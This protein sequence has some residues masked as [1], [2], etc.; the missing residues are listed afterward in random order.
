MI[1][2]PTLCKCG[3]NEI[4]WNGNEYI[5]HHNVRG[6]NNYVYGKGYLRAKNNNGMFNKN[7]S[8][9]S[10][11][12]ISQ[13]RSG[14]CLGNKNPMAQL[15]VRLKVSGENSYLW[16]GGISFGQYSKKFN[17]YLKDKIRNRDNRICKECSK[18]ELENKEKLTVHHIDYNKQNCEEFNLI[19]LC[20]SCNSKVNFNRNYW[21]EHFMKKLEE[22]NLLNY[23]GD[24]I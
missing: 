20:R 8:D 3:C 24:K 7:H 4:V 14:K 10:K 1:K 22:R 15:D 21:E 6:K 16:C 11:S 13:N 19:T 18:T 12:K 23:F 9:I 5:N 2:I 17:N